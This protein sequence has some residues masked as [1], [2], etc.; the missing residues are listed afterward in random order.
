MKQRIISVLTPCHNEEDCVEELYRRIRD[1]FDKLEGYDFIHLFID[2]AST[3]S[4]VDR[5]RRLA[6]LDHRVRAIINTRNFGPIR[7]SYHG[8]LS[9]EGD[10]TI[11]M[12][13]DLQDPVELIPEFIRQWEEGKMIVVGVKTR[14]HENPVVLLLR[15]VYYRALAKMADAELIENFTGFGLYDHRVIQ[16]LRRYDDPYPYFRGLV[17]E[18]GYSLGRIEYTEAERTHGHSKTDIY[19]LINRAMLGLTNHS[20][21]PLRMAT[22]FGTIFAAINF[23]IG[24]IYL[25][26]KLIMWDQFTIGVAPVVIGLF[27]FASVQLIFIG[28][29]GEYVG[30]IYTRVQKKPHVIERERINFP[31]DQN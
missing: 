18:T 28:I 10:A 16:T 24:M 5:I 9:T 25:I 21:V 27:F 4:T 19:T 11:N 30:A 13:S 3:D 15:K 6:A 2:N 7:S 29:I 22:I 20:R 1:Q 31:V 12:A 23:L 17:S 14:S 8:F 26:Y